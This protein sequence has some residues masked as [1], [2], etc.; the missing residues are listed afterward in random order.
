MSPDIALIPGRCEGRQARPESRYHRCPLRGTASRA[1]R[2]QATILLVLPWPENGVY[3]YVPR[4]HRSAWSPAQAVRW[5]LR[6][7]AAV[8]CGAN[9]YPDLRRSHSPWLAL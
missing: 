3:F 9:F 2:R 7:E 6:Q 4:I 8:F 1:L 5:R